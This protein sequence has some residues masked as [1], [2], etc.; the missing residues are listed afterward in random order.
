MKGETKPH[1]EDIT[2][3]EKVVVEINRLLK[4]RKDLEVGVEAIQNH[5]VKN[6]FFRSTT[7]FLIWGWTADEPMN[8]NTRMAFRRF[9]EQEIKNINKKVNNLRKSIKIVEKP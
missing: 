8:D 2:E 3:P 1:N 7:H 5:Y 6:P 4:E 9:L